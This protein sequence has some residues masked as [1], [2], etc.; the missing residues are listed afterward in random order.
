M[1]VSLQEMKRQKAIKNS[2]FQRHRGSGQSRK[3]DKAAESRR[4]AKQIAEFQASGGE[5][6]QLDS[7]QVS[8][9]RSPAFNPGNIGAGIDE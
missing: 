7:Y 8:P 9:Y 2:I 3:R 6:E 4:I 1:S 5:I